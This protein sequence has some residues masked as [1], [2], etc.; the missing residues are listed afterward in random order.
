MKGFRRLTV[1]N[2][3]TGETFQDTANILVSAKGGL[4]QIAWPQIKGLKQFAG[5]LMHSGAWDER[6]VHGRLSKLKRH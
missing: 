5:K 3:K 2:N 1:K 4:N 6:S